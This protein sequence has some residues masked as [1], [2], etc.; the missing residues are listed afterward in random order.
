MEVQFLLFSARPILIIYFPHISDQNFG[1]GR[2]WE[3]S[4]RWKL[5][6]SEPV[7]GIPRKSL[8]LKGGREWE[9]KMMMML[10]QSRDRD[11][12]CS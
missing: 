10:S 1:T 7:W 9:G 3:T 2:V 5:E 11:R 12:E 6:V 8:S 4:V